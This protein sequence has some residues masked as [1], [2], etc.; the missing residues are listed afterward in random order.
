MATDLHPRKVRRKRKKIR[1]GKVTE[2][3]PFWNPYV[4]GNKKGRFRNPPYIQ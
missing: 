2:E 3:S 1:K 4:H